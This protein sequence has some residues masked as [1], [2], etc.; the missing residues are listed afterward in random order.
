MQIN[1]SYPNP[2]QIIYIT[3]MQNV[4]EI[5]AVKSKALSPPQ[6]FYLLIPL[7]RNK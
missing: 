2:P 4:L 1:I 5:E 7:Q 3:L 6:D